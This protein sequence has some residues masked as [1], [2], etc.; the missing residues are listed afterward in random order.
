[1]KLIQQLKQRLQGV[2]WGERIRQMWLPIVFAIGFSTTLCINN[3][4]GL[5]GPQ[6]AAALFFFGGGYL[7]FGMLQLTDAALIWGR[8]EG[9]KTAK[10]I[11]IQSVA[12]VAL[13]IDT[14]WW[15]S[16]EDWSTAVRIGHGAVYLALFTCIFIVPTLRHKDDRHLVRFTTDTFATG[17]LLGVSV[18]MATGALTALL[19]GIEELFNLTFKRLY[20]DLWIVMMGAVFGTLLVMLFPNPEQDGFATPFAQKL[21]NIAGKFIMLPLLVLY[22]LVLYVYLMKIVFMWQ[23][24]E[25]TV[26]WL[27]TVMMAELLLTVFLLYPSI[28]QEDSHRFWHV[29]RQAL[30][31]LALPPLVLM[32]VGLARRVGDYGWTITRIYVVAFNAWC[33]LACALLIAASFKEKKVLTRLIGTF[34]IP[35]VLMSVIPGLNVAE[36]TQRMFTE[37]LEQLISEAEVPFPDHAISSKKVQDWLYQLSDEQAEPIYTKLDY[38]NSTFGPESISKW[39]LDEKDEYGHRTWY[40]W[41]PTK[42]NTRGELFDYRDNRSNTEHVFEIPEGYKTF[43]TIGTNPEVTEKEDGVFV[44]QFP[45]EGIEATIDTRSIDTDLPY[46]SVEAQDGSLLLITQLEIWEQRKSETKE[47]YLQ[48]SFCGYLLSK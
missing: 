29:V 32:S 26:T 21:S 17:I 19:F 18:S 4:G 10:A 36:C 34:C 27:T 3:H 7:L 33:Y 1:M 47:T 41:Y 6:L 11:G 23:L 14:I 25:G 44:L 28:Y 38:M 12:L 35:F 8:N 48:I 37:Q 20:A 13:L 24:P 5:N 30:P 9:M 31:W 42:D 16:D 40:H 43:K 2:E 22:L 46:I 39:V 15:A 45:K